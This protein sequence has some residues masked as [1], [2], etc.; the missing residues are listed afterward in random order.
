MKTIEEIKQEIADEEKIKEESVINHEP[1]GE[2]IEI[3]KILVQ[4]IEE[5]VKE[6]LKKDPNII[7][8][9]ISINVWKCINDCSL[10]TYM[11]EHSY[12]VFE[13]VIKEIKV[14]GYTN[15]MC[16]SPADL[17][18]FSIFHLQPIVR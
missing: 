15:I 14:A 9:N 7:D 17:Y 16:S 5:K 10:Q 3:R 13:T 18:A 11:R 2:L 6:A 4:A 8:I 12:K 1:D